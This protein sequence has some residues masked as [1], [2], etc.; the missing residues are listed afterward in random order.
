M[1]KERLINVIESST[2]KC[3]WFTLVHISV[4]HALIDATCGFILYSLV[5]LGN[6]D[7][8]MFVPAF[9]LYNGLAFA[10]Q[11]AVG[12]LLDRIKQ[13]VDGFIF[14]AVFVAIAG[15]IFPELPWV[16]VVL[17]GL[18]NAVFHA[19]AGAIALNIDPRKAWAP[20][21]F[22]APG[23]I[24]L[25]LGILAGKSGPLAAWFLP[26]VVMIFAVSGFWM[27]Y[28]EI[29]YRVDR[30]ISSVN[31]FVLVLLLLLLSVS[32]RAFVGMAAA[33]PWKSDIY[34]LLALSVGV[35]LG[36]GLGSFLADRFGWIK[37]S[38]GALVI[39]GVLL[40]F[41]AKFAMLGILGM[42]F[43]QMTMPVTLVAVANM[44]PDKP[45]FAFGLPCLALFL[46]SVPILL[47]LLPT[48][49]GLGLTALI[50][51]SAVL[52]W[53]ALKMYFRFAG[54]PS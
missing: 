41:G 16:A 10:L 45:S 7:S 18:G 33:L 1:K 12:L 19:G 38:V 53:V 49:E 17:S 30:K 42:F 13:P 24:G 40:F 22:V 46:G 35:V 8:S 20:G 31:L 2:G 52:L 25:T 5:R 9:L 48:L 26:L 39:S 21:V 50:M 14:G 6:V 43:F 32:A 15:V 29:K 47:R 3:Q 54:K 28:P 4:F 23:A 37:I 44:F 34:L 51:L 27:K 36:K 11:P